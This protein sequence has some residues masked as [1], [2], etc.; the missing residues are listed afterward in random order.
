[1]GGGDRLRRDALAI[2]DAGVNAV[3]PHRLV[4]DAL[5]GEPALGSA[6]G[7]HLVAVGKAAAAMA[8]G[9][10]EV[11]GD[12]IRAGVVLA[13]RGAISGAP[14]G[15]RLFEGG[16]PIPSAEG[17]RGAEAIRELARDL[18]EGDQ[19]LCL[20]SGGGSAL[21]TLPAEGVSLADVQVV[22]DLLLR[23]G[24]TIEELNCVRKH[25]ERLKGGR[26]AD[27]A[28]PAEIAALVLSDVVGDPLDVIA[29]G[30][31]TP[32]PTTFGE[33]VAVLD[34]YGVD[35]RLPAAIRERLEA[36]VS[37]RV[38]ET[39][40]ADEVCF[41]RVRATVIGNNRIA[42]TAALEAA[43]GLGYATRLLTT[44]CV[45]EAREVGRE[46]ALL[47][48]AL[49][50]A[51]DGLTPPAC[52]IAAGETTVTVVG[53]GRGGRNQEVVL[54]AALELAGS[55]RVLIA[56]MGTDGIDGPTDAAGA[57]A[58]GR[59]MG[60][61][62]ERGVD[63]RARLADN[64]AYGFFEALD[65]LILT[66]PTGTNVMDLMLVLVAPEGE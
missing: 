16:H 61:A 37:G 24:A 48:R 28:S 5:G 11:L 52:L 36:G 65:D 19:L 34:R 42:A 41:E 51:V 20:V 15:L 45:G 43:Q 21:M 1:M 23:A 35:D 57:M 9:A 64:D 63:A 44:Q 31:V 30:P 7:V 27:L 33:A 54:G 40:K 22:T 46:L 25:I 58:D 56:S 62:Q 13:P 29:S 4:R 14:S 38:R 50:C 53:E 59:S 66:G 6:G 10:T 17:A 32:D 2:L 49:E 26:L 60:R 39:P 55:D 8:A 12:R 18:E 47:A 3:E